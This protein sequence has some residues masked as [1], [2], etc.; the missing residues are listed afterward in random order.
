MLIYDL[1]APLFSYSDAKGGV[2]FAMLC[3]PACTVG[4]NGSSL[5]FIPDYLEISLNDIKMT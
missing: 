2:V 3:L 4:R 5:G 1:L